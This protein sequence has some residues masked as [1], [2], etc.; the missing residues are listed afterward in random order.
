MLSWKRSKRTTQI[1]L[2]RKASNRTSQSWNYLVLLD[3]GRQV[4][5]NSP[6][7]KI[8][9]LP[10]TKCTRGEMFD[11]DTILRQELDQVAAEFS[12]NFFLVDRKYPGP[13]R[14]SRKLICIYCFCFHSGVKKIDSKFYSD[15][16]GADFGT[17][18]VESLQLCSML[19]RKD[20]N[21]YYRV[22]H[23]VPLCEY[24]WP[25]WSLDLFLFLMWHTAVEFSP[26]HPTTRSFGKP[27]HAFR[28]RVNILP[29]PSLSILLFVSSLAL[30]LF[31]YFSMPSALWSEDNSE[32]VYFPKWQRRC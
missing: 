32:A 27:P 4:S 30:I 25:L 19:H 10:F 14:Q 28:R 29:N 26:S 7:K 9:D 8:L 15:F 31:L 5:S 6:E 23:S 22:L 21:G 13:F 18:A 24:D 11:C 2:E 20:E 3:W 12:G 16:A 17:Q 1:W